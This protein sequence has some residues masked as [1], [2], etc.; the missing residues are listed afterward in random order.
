MLR[1]RNIHYEGSDRVRGLGA[2]GIGAM[3]LLARRTGL[4]AAIDA[5][6]DLLKV[7]Q[8]YHESDHVLNIAYNVLCGGHCLEDIE[9]RRN[10]EGFLDALGTTSIPDPTT[11]GD[12]CRRFDE[13][14][15]DSLME[16][17]NEARVRVWSAQPH[18]FFE[19]AI[20]DADGTLVE[21][22][23]ECKEGMDVNYKK[24]WGYH[25]LLVSLANTQEP[26]FLVNRSGN[27]PSHEGAA[28][29][30]DRA[31]DLLRRAGFRRVLLRGDTDFSQTRHLDRW[32]AQGVRFVFGYDANK[33]LVGV[34]NSLADGGW[35]PLSRE[36]KYTV[37]TKPRAQPANVKEQIIVQ[38][39]FTNIR[40]VS[41][42][43][44][45]CE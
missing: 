22:T 27:R 5:S 37:K 6:L 4:T 25:P 39:E 30:L 8:P 9:I 21:T 7:H 23:G 18:E 31:V 3:H 32:D 41:E 35:R 19:E 1:G 45:P 29:D 33:K 24:L 38:R 43:L 26:I 10:D 14:A 44:A 11:A 2:G 17:A 13:P 34:A 15:I 28:H 36:P 20:V 40:L 16:A 42:D 12:F